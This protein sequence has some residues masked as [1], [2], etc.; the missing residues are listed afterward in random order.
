M[1]G[2]TRKVS[3]GVKHKKKKIFALLLFLTFFL[4]D[5]V[6]TNVHTTTCI[7]SVLN[8]PSNLPPKPLSSIPTHMRQH[9]SVSVYLNFLVCGVSC[10]LGKG[11]ATSSA[12]SRS[13]E[14]ASSR[15]FGR[16]W[17]SFVLPMQS[18]H[19]ATGARLLIWAFKWTTLT[20]V[21]DLSRRGDAAQVWEVLHLLRQVRAPLPTPVH[22]WILCHTGVSASIIS[23][24]AP[25]KI[26]FIGDCSLVAS[27]WCNCM[28]GQAGHGLG[29]FSPRLRK[30][31]TGKWL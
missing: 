14:G 3:K 21:A 23:R 1:V 26:Q 11:V 24:K 13:G 31:K 30:T 6:D 9:N 17:P 8:I 2:V 10:T 4:D 27:V 25:T 18:Y 19:F 12:F 28:A 22:S 20:Q 7:I 29:C 16:T 5:P 15:G